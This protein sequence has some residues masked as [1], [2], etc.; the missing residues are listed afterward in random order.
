MLPIVN[1]NIKILSNHIYMKLWLF[2]NVP[3]GNFLILISPLQ[4]PQS[5]NNNNIITTNYLQ[6]LMIRS[7]VLTFIIPF[8]ILNEHDELRSLGK[9]NLNTLD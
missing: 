7:L 8:I 6:S 2:R 5:I 3:T 9:W 4:S 1:N